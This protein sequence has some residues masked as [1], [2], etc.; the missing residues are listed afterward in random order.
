M[1]LGYTNRLHFRELTTEPGILER[2]VRRVKNFDILTKGQNKNV[3][4]YRDVCTTRKPKQRNLK[5]R[6][7]GKN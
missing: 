3:S 7:K 2:S 5:N 6:A 4:L 1:E